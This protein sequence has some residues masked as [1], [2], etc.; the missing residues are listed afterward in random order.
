MFALNGT[1]SIFAPARR[2]GGLLIVGAMALSLGACAHNVADGPT[3]Q[4]QVTTD[5]GADAGAPALGAAAGASTAWGSAN[6]G[7]EEHYVY[8]GGRDPKTGL[9]FTQL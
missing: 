9:A 7:A 8:R 6:E 1:A 2:F 4:W 3:L 5:D